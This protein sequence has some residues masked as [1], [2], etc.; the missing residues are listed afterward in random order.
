[1]LTLLEDFPDHVLAIHGTGEV[2]ADDY[3]E[4]LVPAVEERLARH[5]RVR[6]L[7]L[8][9]ANF[10]GFTGGAAWEDT[11]VGMRHFT[12][13]ERIAV[14]TDSDWVRR[15]VRGFGFALPGE[16]RVYDLDD[17][18]EA[19]TWIREPMDPGELEF[20]LDEERGLLVLEPKDELEVGDFARVAAV[21]DSWLSRHDELAG[22]VI[23]APHFPGWDDFAALS[24]HMGFVREHHRQVRR[25]ALVTD[26]HFLGAL[27]RLASLFVHA[28][29]RHF[30][31][32]DRDAAFAWA[33][34]PPSQG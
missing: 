7:Y 5:R 21:V 4:V 30:G 2:T 10:T 32:E 18:D 6:L 28:E 25:V 20:H 24:A 33:V 12:A 3:R 13:F 19:R 11:K 22:I 1:M 34:E 16:V 23:L 29:I 8:L 26:S 9:D 31:S 15:M 14:V 17:Q 27:P